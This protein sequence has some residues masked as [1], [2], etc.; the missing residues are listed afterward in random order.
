MVFVTSTKSFANIKSVNPAKA[1]SMPG[2]VDFIS[3]KD[4]PGNNR[5]GHVV[6]DD[7]EIFATKQV[8]SDMPLQ[9]P[10]HVC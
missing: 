2:V 10:S 8:T 5:W 7:E 4:V 6:K 9:L 1:L 3:Y